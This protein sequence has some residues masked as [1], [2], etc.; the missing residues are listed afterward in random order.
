MLSTAGKDVEIGA[1]GGAVGV[2]GPVV[3]ERHLKAF[4]RTERGDR[5]LSYT[6]TH[7]QR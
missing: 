1:P 7:T 5:Q 4:P 6:L 2:R 3:L